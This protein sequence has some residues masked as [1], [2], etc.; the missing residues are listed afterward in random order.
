VLWFVI[1]ELLLP[2]GINLDVFLSSLII[3]DIEFM[4][5]V[6]PAYVAYFVFDSEDDHK[7]SCHDMA[8]SILTQ[9]SS[10]SDR[11]FGL[12]SRLYSSQNLGAR[13]PTSYVLTECLI[14][15]LS[16]PGQ[17]P[18]YI[19]LDAI[20]ECPNT[21]GVPSPREEILVLLKELVDLRLPNLWLC[22]TCRPAIDIRTHLEP[23]WRFRLS[24]QDELGQKQDIVKYVSDIV[25]SDPN[26]G[27]WGGDD[28]QLVIDTL[29]ERAHGMLVLH[30]VP[31]V[32]SHFLLSGSAVPPARWMTYDTA[33]QCRL[34]YAVF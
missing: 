7:Q 8:T 4:C 26:F 30:C 25:G 32:V 27:T 15:M 5:K 34:L 20:D 10:Q 9:L 1:S 22:V 17:S 29:C 12:L 21:C 18:V 19:I 31:L 14:D 3:E 13:I 11:C 23:L 16:L 24:L 33:S 28:K 2:K 6:V